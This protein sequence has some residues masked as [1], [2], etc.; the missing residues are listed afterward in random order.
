MGYYPLINSVVEQVSQLCVLKTCS[1]WTSQDKHSGALIQFFVIQKAMFIFWHVVIPYCIWK[2][3]PQDLKYLCDS[4]CL[5][6]TSFEATWN[7]PAFCFFFSKSSSAESYTVVHIIREGRVV[8][9]ANLML[10]DVTA[11]YCV[12]T[13]DIVFPSNICFHSALTHSCL[14]EGMVCTQKNPLNRQIEFLQLRQWI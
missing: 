11:K 7:F 1:C 6:G 10:L 14:K 3:P 8:S 4:F 2:I 9:W 12:T 5:S 13:F